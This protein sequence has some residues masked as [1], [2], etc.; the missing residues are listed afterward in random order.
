MT[1]GANGIVENLREEEQR[2]RS[3]HSETL[4]AARGLED[5]LARV[6]EAIRALLGEASVVASERGP[7]NRKGTFSSE[8][9]IA[10]LEELLA[11]KK[12]LTLADANKHVAARVAAEGRSKSGLHFRV[13]KALNDAR[14]VADGDHWKLRP[15]RF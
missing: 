9:V 5:D 2:L 11:A 3:E 4:K 1:T 15:R 12:K 13:K 10:I 7:K 6:Q 14:F 8:E